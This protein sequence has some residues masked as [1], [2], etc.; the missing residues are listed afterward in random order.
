[1]NVYC[2]H[3]ESLKKVARKNLGYKLRWYAEDHDGAVRNG[4][5]N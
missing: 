3:Y 2:T 1:M 5:R 4:A